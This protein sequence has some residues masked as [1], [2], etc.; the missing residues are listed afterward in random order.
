MSVF[1]NLI[2]VDQSGKWNILVGLSGNMYRQASVI[3]KYVWLLMSV[4]L[5][6]Q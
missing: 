1:D 3:V 4:D 5:M 2:N 6:P